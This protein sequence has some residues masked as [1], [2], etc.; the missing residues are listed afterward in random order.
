[1]FLQGIRELELP[2]AHGEGKFV[3]RDA[4][5]LDRL[6][7]RGQVVLTYGLPGGS[8]PAGTVVQG[9]PVMPYPVNPNGSEA[10]IAGICDETG[11]VF[12]LM[13]HPERN[14]DGIQHPQ[15][16][17]RPN[18]SEGDGLALFRNAVRFF[19]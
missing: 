2:I 18:R 16:T 8:S 13:P 19:D 12:G 7:S 9:A 3:C 10:N 14:V 1:V 4:T 11:R 17:R 15:W 5:V 6:Q